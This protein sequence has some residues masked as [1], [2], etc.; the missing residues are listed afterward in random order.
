MCVGCSLHVTQKQL[1][2]SKLSQYV[3]SKLW[4][5][6]YTHGMHHQQAWRPSQMQSQHKHVSVTLYSLD[7]KSKCQQTLHIC[8]H[9]PQVYSNPQLGYQ[10][11]VDVYFLSSP[12]CS[13]TN[14]TGCC[15]GT[16]IYIAHLHCWVSIIIVLQECTVDWRRHAWPNPSPFAFHIHSCWFT[17]FTTVETCWYTGITWRL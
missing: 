17:S 4:V 7:D 14:D 1:C 10:Q 12:Q 15:C 16:R 3:S 5:T 9:R 11:M 2:Q 8:C 13:D 6:C